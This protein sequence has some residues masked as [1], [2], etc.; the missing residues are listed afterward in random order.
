MDG[1]NGLDR[2]R[3]WISWRIYYGLEGVNRL[4][5]VNRLDKRKWGEK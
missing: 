2:W 5:A 1:G 3:K 4:D